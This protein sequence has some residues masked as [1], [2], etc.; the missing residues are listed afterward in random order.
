M[1]TQYAHCGPNRGPLASRRGS[2]PRHSRR[3]RFWSGKGKRA[4]HGQGEKGTPRPCN[5]CVYKLQGR[6]VPT[7]GSATATGNR[8]LQPSCQFTVGARQTA[9]QNQAAGAEWGYGRLFLARKGKTE[10]TDRKTVF[11]SPVFCSGRCFLCI[12]VFSLSSVCA[13]AVG[14]GGRAFGLF[15]AG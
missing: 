1:L 3:A 7:W 15:A 6:G 9:N 13:A 2:G 14:G 10:A 8:G 4:H 11:S 5:S 12:F